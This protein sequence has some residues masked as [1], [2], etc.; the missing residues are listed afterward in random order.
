MPGVHNYVTQAIYFLPQLNDELE[1]IYRIL[2][3]TVVIVNIVVFYKK[4]RQLRR[5]ER[6]RFCFL[7]V[8][9]NFK[10]NLKKAI[11]K[12]NDQKYSYCDHRYL[13]SNLACILRN[14]FLWPCHTFWSH[15]NFRCTGANMI[16]RKIHHDI[17]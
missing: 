12:K 1:N 7:T 5:T 11:N 10:I 6:Q 17:L 13:S 3:D 4:K 14:I 8:E 2:S 9:K 16:Y 15:S